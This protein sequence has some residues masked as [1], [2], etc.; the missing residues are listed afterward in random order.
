MGDCSSWA[1]QWAALAARHRVLAYSRRHSSPNRFARGR[2]GDA[3]HSVQIDIDDLAG[4]MQELHIGCAH[5]V[6]TSYGALVALGFAIKNPDRVLSLTL[7]EPPLHGWADRS[8]SG[9]R[10]LAAFMRDVWQPAALSFERGEARRAIQLLVDGIWGRAVFDSMP[11]ERVAAALRNANAMKV[12]TRSAMPFSDLSREDV[13]TLAVP[14]LLVQGEF[15]SAL[16]AQVI[17]EL[18]RVLP[19]AAL[20]VIPRAGHGSPAENPD[21]FN[22]AVLGLVES[23]EGFAG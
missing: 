8:R 14:T 15:A 10:L 7:A 4:F 22:R 1:P 21:A 5:L 16:H 23:A 20:A 13:A 3:G 18:A 9:S 6:G 19:A 17:E 11:P 12:L 2:A